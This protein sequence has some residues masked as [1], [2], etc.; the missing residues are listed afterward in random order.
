MMFGA[1]AP[2]FARQDGVRV[3]DHKHGGISVVLV[4]AHAHTILSPAEGRRRD[5]R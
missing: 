1:V 5:R 2:R 4:I 3:S